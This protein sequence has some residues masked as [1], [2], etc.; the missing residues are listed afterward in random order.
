MVLAQEL[1]SELELEDTE[2]GRRWRQQEQEEAA[3][4]GHL[5]PTRGVPGRCEGEA[6]LMV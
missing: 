3:P 5:L 6:F 2:A 4:G 1:S